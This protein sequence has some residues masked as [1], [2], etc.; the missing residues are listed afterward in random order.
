MTRRPCIGSRHPPPP[1]WTTLDDAPCVQCAGCWDRPT[2]ATGL[3]ALERR[4]HEHVSWIS[5]TVGTDQG[6]DRDHR[7]AGAGRAGR[8]DG[9]S[10]ARG[11]RRGSKGHGRVA[12][13]GCRGRSSPCVLTRTDCAVA[14]AGTAAATGCRDTG[15]ACFLGIDPDVYQ[16]P[17]L[18]EYVQSGDDLIC[19]TRNWSAYPPEAFDIEFMRA[20]WPMLTPQDQAATEGAAF[21]FVTT[22]WGPPSAPAGT[23][24]TSR[25]PPTFRVKSSAASKNERSGSSSRFRKRISKRWGG[26]R[27]TCRFHFH[28]PPPPTCRT[29]F[30]AGTSKA[31]ASPGTPMAAEM[32]S[33]WTVARRSTR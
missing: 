33:A 26:S 22:H 9:G 20:F 11:R 27:S 3:T 23:S 10:G 7:R 31:T 18:G 15:D 25:H 12:V 6:R 4:R 14:A 28:R 17:L 1:R 2:S 8:A 30:V 21:F 16:M 24:A 19:A 5:A 29:S 32:G 13:A